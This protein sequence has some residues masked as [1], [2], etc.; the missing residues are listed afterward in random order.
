VALRSYQVSWKSISYFKVVIGYKRMERI[1]FSQSITTTTT[2]TT[3]TITTT[4]M[5]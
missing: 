3:T 2:T 4:I 5:W 1:H